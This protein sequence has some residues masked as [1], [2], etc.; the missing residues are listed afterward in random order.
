MYY[1]EALVKTEEKN[2]FIIENIEKPKLEEK[3]VL[4]KVSHCGICGS[5]L[6]AANHDKGYE[7][8]PKP[9]VLGHEI[10]GTVIDVAD[11]R[12][13]D[14]LKN[15]VVIVPTKYCGECQQCL[16]GE[17]NICNN[18]SGVGL[19]FD[20]GMAEY[21]KVLPE[22]LVNIPSSLSLEIAALAEPLSVAM[23]AVK[24][25]KR[26]IKGKDVL[27]QG[28]GIIGLFT[29]IIAENSGANVTISGLERDEEHRLSKA[30]LFSIETETVEARN[31]N[32]F[33]FIFEC[34]GSS[35]ALETAFNRMDK[36]GALIMVALYKDS[37]NIPAN[38]MV[39]GEIDIISS[40]SSL[41][42]DIEDSI[43]LLSTQEKKFKKLIDIYSLENGNLAFQ[44]ARHQKVLKPIIRL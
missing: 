11:K 34:S 18:I 23:H 35:A 9:I 4:V 30:K 6:H 37:I 43:N 41:R 33:H 28:C 27:V 25:M 44:H 12:D 10:S 40:Y 5:D 1:I 20:G 13:L 42:V 31:K 14:L 15:N 39:R 8:V 22:Q 38:I 32:M 24:R 26:D 16:S 36:G 2:K 19:H 29:A 21:I 7:F 17:F 3:E